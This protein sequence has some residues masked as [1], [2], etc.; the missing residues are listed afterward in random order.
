[1]VI[2]AAALFALGAAVSYAFADMA[3]RYGL[4]HTTPIIGSTIGRVFS[5]STLAALIW[6]TGAQFPPW[7]THYL[8]LLLAGV[9]NPGLF[10]VFFMF[11]I[12]KI[13]VSRAAPIKGS[14]PLIAAFLA[15]LFLGERPAP[16][17]LA[18]VVL[19]VLG[20]AVISSGK[21]GG[22]WRRI[23]ALWPLAAAVFAG[24]G[25]IFW[26][27]GL[28]AFPH[29]LAGALVGMTAALLT[30]A[31]YSVLFKREQILGGVKAAWRPFMLGGIVGA[32]GNFFYASALRSGEVFRM[33]SL[34]QI[35]PL[36]TVLLALIL[37]RKAESITWRVP[38]GAVLTVSG[39]ILVNLRF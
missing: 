18:G 3:V 35:S 33:V 7:G 22:R 34:I 8:W 32:I 21:T 1:M 15:I 2:D 5:V 20:V 19:V 39:A 12:S 10:A 27:K 23:H 30:V 16:G 17:Q 6:I 38:A 4:Q 29:P 25:A 9:F 26:R 36:L 37:L 24:T 31:L 28:P 11:G 14:S 13:G